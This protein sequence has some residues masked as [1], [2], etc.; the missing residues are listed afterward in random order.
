MW[1]GFILFSVAVSPPLTILPWDGGLNLC[2]P[3]CLSGCLSVC[4][5]P[6]GC[7]PSIQFI[8]IQSKAFQQAAEYD[9]GTDRT[10]FVDPDPVLC[11]PS[12]AAHHNHMARA[13]TCRGSWFCLH[14]R[15]RRRRCCSPAPTDRSCPFKSIQFALVVFDG[16]PVHVCAYFVFWCRGD[17]MNGPWADGVMDAGDGDDFNAETPSCPLGTDCS[18]CGLGVCILYLA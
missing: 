12:L 8:S 3:A 9:R 11:K 13:R 7:V 4:L 1:L 16:C 5:S 10:M 17:F 14:R 6:L 18:D 2:L 15:R